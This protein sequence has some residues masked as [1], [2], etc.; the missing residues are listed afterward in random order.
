[1]KLEM[2]QKLARESFEEKIRKV[3]QAHP[4][5]ESLSPAGFPANPGPALRQM[6]TTREGHRRSVHLNRFSAPLRTG[7]GLELGTAFGLSQ[8]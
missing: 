5:G 7:W 8:Q 2:R 6:R 3:G 1:M 4:A